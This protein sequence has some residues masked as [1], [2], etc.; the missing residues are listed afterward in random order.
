MILGY[1][2]R[3]ISI[4]IIVNV[5]MVLSP[6]PVVIKIALLLDCS[7]RQMRYRRSAGVPRHADAVSGYSECRASWLNGGW[8]RVGE[9][10]RDGRTHV[11]LRI[12]KA[13]CQ[14][15]CG[16]NSMPLGR[17]R[18]KWQLCMPAQFESPTAKKTNA[19]LLAAKIVHN[20]SGKLPK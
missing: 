13:G 11:G 15:Q 3:P 20:L 4:Y 1:C 9:R 10:V 7:W 17:I 5:A 12:S 18:S 19:H 16:C 6:M 2:T 8:V 14:E